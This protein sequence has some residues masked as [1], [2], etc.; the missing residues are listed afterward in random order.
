MVDLD[1]IRALLRQDAAWA[2]YALGDLDPR[3]QRHCQWFARD[4]SVALVYREFDTPILFAAGSP[5]I[6]ADVPPLD[7]CLLQIPEQFAGGLKERYAIDWMRPMERLALVPGAYVR[8]SAGVAMVEPLGPLH[9]TELR[10]LFAD[11]RD[12]GDEPDFF[13]ASQ[14]EDETF[15]G[16]REAGRLVA[17]GGTHL[18]SAA[19]SV[20]TIG[21][22]YTCRGYRGR[23][24]ASAVTA[25]IVDRL[26]ARDTETIVLNVKAGNASARRVYE[27]LGFT[28]HTRY[29]EGRAVAISTP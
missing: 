8:P 27:R 9:E 14:L 11:G 1:V 23:G 21:N 4:G 28:F 10:E 18:Y 3:R 26:I 15:F 7:A 12:T 16:V 19:E 24:H 6:L 17:A 2:A 20:G 25:A 29:W 13:I 5:G 22:I